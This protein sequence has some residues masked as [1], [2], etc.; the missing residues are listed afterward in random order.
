[1]RAGPLIVEKMAT[2]MVIT[3]GIELT[4]KSAKPFVSE[5]APAL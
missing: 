2:K 3:A 1:L 5:F 4:S